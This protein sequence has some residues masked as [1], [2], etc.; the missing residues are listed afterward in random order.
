MRDLINNGAIDLVLAEASLDAVDRGLRG[1]VET[2]MMRYRG[3]LRAGAPLPEVETQA[4]VIEGLLD[5]ARGLLDST[6]LSAS[7]TF[8]SAFVILLREGLEAIL[9]VA[10][11]YALLVRAGRRDA[12]AYL[13]GGWIAGADR[14]RTDVARGLVRRSR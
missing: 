4:A 3:L 11:I 9:V 1:E 14:R 5:R 6:R 12:L 10:A 2:Q 13:H 7:A 8:L